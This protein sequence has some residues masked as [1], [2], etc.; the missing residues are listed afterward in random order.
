MYDFLYCINL[1]VRGVFTLLQSMFFLEPDNYQV[2]YQY[3]QTPLLFFNFTSNLNY[4]S[5]KLF[6]NQTLN[7]LTPTEHKNILSSNYIHF[8]FDYK[9]GNYISDTFSSNFIHQFPSFLK[10]TGSV[11]L[12]P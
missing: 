10:I 3:Q 9:S 12:F 1:D 2:K 6:Y 4:L 11:K 8:S 7:F 5:N